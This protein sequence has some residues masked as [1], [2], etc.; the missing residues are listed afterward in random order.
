MSLS[1]TVHA[2]M[3]GNPSLGHPMAEMANGKDDGATKPSNPKDIIGSRKIDFSLVPWTVIVCAAGALLE[4]ALKYGRF[5]WRI[6][7]VRA[8]IY[9]SALCRHI[10]KWWNGQDHDKAT[11][12]H[13]LDNAIAC[14]IILR[15]A[16]LYGKL[17][18]DRPPCPD[19]DAMA[20]FIDGQEDLVAHLKYLFKEHS[21][22][23]FTIADTP[24]SSS[25]F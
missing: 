23:Q 25:L 16:E 1:S 5:N 24:P 18:D 11:R 19:P 3:S 13:H 2:A 22:R 17:T 6:S 9:H 15:D 8:S 21:P 12:V 10:A 7:G 20:R 4:G 14:L